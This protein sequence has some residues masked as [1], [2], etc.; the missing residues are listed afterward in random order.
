MS[1]WI[2]RLETD[3]EP[4]CLVVIEPVERTVA[5]V[6]F[7]SNVSTLLICE[8]FGH[9]NMANIV[10]P[11]LTTQK[12]NIRRFAIYANQLLQDRIRG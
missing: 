2:K 7:D 12:V 8:I 5:T 6:K 11:Y 3:L 9:K 4:R 10:D 1:L